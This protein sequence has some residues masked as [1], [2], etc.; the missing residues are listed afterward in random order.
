MYTLHVS[1]DEVRDGEESNWTSI[2]LVV[3]QTLN[4]FTASNEQITFS[5][6]LTHWQTV[7]LDSPYSWD[8]LRHQV[9]RSL[10]QHL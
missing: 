3:N 5:L 10:V 7:S 8:I 1:N 2:S 4:S 6:G 9:G